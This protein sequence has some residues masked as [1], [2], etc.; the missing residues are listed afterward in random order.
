MK[1]AQLKAAAQKASEA[2]AKAWEKYV[3]SLG[4]RRKP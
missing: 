4:G 2:A 1:P 3:I